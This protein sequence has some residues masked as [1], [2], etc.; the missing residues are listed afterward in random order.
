MTFLTT[1]LCVGP[2][3]EMRPEW[4]LLLTC[5]DRRIVNSYHYERCSTLSAWSR[6][7]TNRWWAK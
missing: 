4:L 6:T 5:S 7:D 2:V 1:M 3:M